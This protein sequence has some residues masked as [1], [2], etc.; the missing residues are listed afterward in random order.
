[1][2]GDARMSEGVDQTTSSHVNAAVFFNDTQHDQDRGHPVPAMAE[3]EDYFVVEIT[4]LDPPMHS[5]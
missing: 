4:P 2:V 1:V 5:K 3:L